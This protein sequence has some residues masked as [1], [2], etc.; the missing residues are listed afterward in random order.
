MISCF[1]VA[2]FTGVVSCVLGMIIVRKWYNVKNTVV[3]IH[4]SMSKV[5]KQLH[6]SIKKKIGM[7]WHENLIIRGNYYTCCGFKAK[8]NV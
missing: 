2:G 4:I 6:F 3:S 1:I 8:H 7:T 5:A